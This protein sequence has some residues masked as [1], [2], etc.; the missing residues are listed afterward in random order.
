LPVA[1][2][3]LQLEGVRRIVHA[4]DDLLFL[5]PFHPRRQVKG[6]RRISAL[7]AA[8]LVTVYDEGRAADAIARLEELLVEVKTRAFYEE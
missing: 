4:Q 1:L 5:A 3:A 8:D 2:L 6:E 7:I